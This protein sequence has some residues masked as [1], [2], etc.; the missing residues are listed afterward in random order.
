MYN[1][2]LFFR[3]YFFF[4]LFLGLETICL[5]LFFKFNTYQNAVMYRWSNALSGPI[6]TI[7]HQIDEYFFLRRSNRILSDEI[8][9]LKSRM[10]EAIYI[11][12][13]HLFVRRDTIFQIEYHFINAKVISNSTNK[14]NN[15]LMINKGILQG[16]QSHMGVIV[17]NKIV[18]QVINVSKHFS[19]I[20]SVLHK[21]TK[22]SAKFLKNSQL[23]SVEWPGGDYLQGIV[24]EIPKHIL[25][26]PGDTIITS[27]NSEVYP[28]GIIIGT[29]E[30]IT[31]DPD[32]NF[33]M[34]KIRLLT[35][36][37]GLNYVEVV[38]DMFRKEKMS[39]KTSFDNL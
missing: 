6:N 16:V 30:E 4:F 2:Y 32:E 11:A 35:D 7:S 39:L 25:A 21:D 19:W 37:N 12:D 5:I 10:P 1:L 24:K 9:F 14:R 13:T 34:A 20:M 23:V 22:L 15:Y 36:F 27:G 38:V 3:R 17:G 26:L 33:N 28:E 29:L 8:T 18:G 31:S